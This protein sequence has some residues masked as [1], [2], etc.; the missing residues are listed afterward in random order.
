MNMVEN[1][2]AYRS[3]PDIRG[4]SEA[5]K[6][7]R[8]N[9]FRRIDRKLRSMDLPISDIDLDCLRESEGRYAQRMSTV[10]AKASRHTGV[11]EEDREKSREVLGD[12]EAAVTY[13]KKPVLD[14]NSANL[15]DIY[16]EL[17]NGVSQILDEDYLE[18]PF[19]QNT[20]RFLQI[21]PHLTTCSEVCNVSPIGYRLRGILADSFTSNALLRE[22]YSDDFCEFYG[23]MLEEAERLRENEG[24]PQKGARIIPFPG[25]RAGERNEFKSGAEK[26][27]MADIKKKS[28]FPAIATQKGGGWAAVMFLEDDLSKPVSEDDKAGIMKAK[29]LI[30]GSDLPNEKKKK[31]LDYLKNADKGDRF[32]VTQAESVAYGYVKGYIPQEQFEFEVRLMDAW[33]AGEIDRFLKKES[34]ALNKRIMPAEEK[35]KLNEMFELV[36]TRSDALKAV[37]A[38]ALRFY[39]PMHNPEERLD[40]I[41]KMAYILSCAKPVEEVAL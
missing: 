10:L 22:K 20:E 37:T 6:S 14:K 7:E 27:D 9:A 2:L 16:D 15:A 28:L 5:Q 19:S 31:L 4:L 38:G 34:K 13:L 33:L 30:T 23:P 39:Y 1:G 21:E 18:R 41:G 11:S 3:V 8:L 25:P 24:R 32:A 17:V 40:M 35:N 29:N 12:L 26:E 36:L